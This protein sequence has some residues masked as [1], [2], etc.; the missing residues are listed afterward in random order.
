MT[1][2]AIVPVLADILVDE[3]GLP[4]LQ[5]VRLYQVTAVAEEEEG[6]E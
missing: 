3:G 6:N 1:D 4:F 5:R 2:T